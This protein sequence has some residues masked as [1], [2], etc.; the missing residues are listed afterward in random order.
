MLKDEGRT[1][2]AKLLQEF[3]R[4]KA[5]GTDE[6]SRF[7]RLVD[8]AQEGFEAEDNA[9]ASPYANNFLATAQRQTAWNHGDAIHVGYIV[10]GRIAL[11]QGQIK[12]A[13]E[14]LLKA[15]GRQDRPNSIYLATT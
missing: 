15:G 11:K 3:E 13:R 6:S 7:S 9:K 14:Y 8:L 5:A 2:A 10:L 4:A 12:Q 1:E